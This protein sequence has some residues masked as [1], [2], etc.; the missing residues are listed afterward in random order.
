M[1]AVA[2][3]NGKGDQTI[4]TMVTFSVCCRPARIPK[5]QRSNWLGAECQG[6][7]GLVWNY[8]LNALITVKSHIVKFTF[9]PL[10]YLKKH[11]DD[12]P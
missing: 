7:L 10:N 8:Q 6:R 12:V 3:L 2:V 1:Q 5:G 9:K 4:T 11:G